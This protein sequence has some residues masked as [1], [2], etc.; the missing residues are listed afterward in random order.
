MI[1]VYDTHIAEAEVLGTCFGIAIGDSIR[2]I[3][4]V[5]FLSQEVVKVAS[6]AVQA[7]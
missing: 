1:K 7:M 5:S 6:D 4:R 3:R 2:I